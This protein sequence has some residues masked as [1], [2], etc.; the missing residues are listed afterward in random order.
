MD[1]VAAIQALMKI[2]R[3]RG[4]ANV[5]GMYVRV[6]RMDANGGRSCKESPVV[7]TQYTPCIITRIGARNGIY[8][9]HVNKHTLQTTTKPRSVQLGWFEFINGRGRHVCAYSYFIP[10]FM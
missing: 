4:A 10:T 6:L 1:T 7:R 9:I 8:V 2:E 5:S 3:R